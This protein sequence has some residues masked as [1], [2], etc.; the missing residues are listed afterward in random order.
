MPRIAVLGAGPAGLAC[1]LRLLR[2]GCKVTVYEADDRAGGM[3]AHFDFDGLDIERFYHFVCTP[4]HPLIDLL[5]ELG[6]ED[7]LEWRAGTMGYFYRG[8]TH[9]WGD[10]LA[11][12]RF[13][14]LSLVSKFRYA[15]HTWLCIRRS[16][17]PGLDDRNAKDWVRRWVGNEAFEILWRPLFDLKFFEYANNLSAAWIRARIQRL[18]RSRKNL[19]VEKL[20]VLRGGSK[21]LIDSLL[22]EIESRGGQV[23]L[24]DPAIEILIE[25]GRATA[26][27]SQ[28]GVER[29]DAV[30][31]TM[32]IPH[33]AKIVPA[34]PANLRERYQRLPNIAAICVLFKLRR[35]LTKYFWLNTTDPEIDIPGVVEYSNLQTL[36]DNVVYVPYY[37]PQTHPRFQFSNERLCAESFGYL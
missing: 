25:Q 26:V 11:L 17:W 12:L 13:P 32:P 24:R 5:A 21:V 7:K 8:R 15:L 6:I 18:G 35:P 29:F 27:R 9:D 30:A 34:M 2:S 28:T 4:D 19:F 36:A 1:A 37:L 14:H 22:D 23:R 16:H 31:S 10:P 33:L 3:S 20:G